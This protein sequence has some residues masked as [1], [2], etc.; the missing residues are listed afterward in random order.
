MHDNKVEQV[1]DSLRSTVYNLETM[2][3]GSDDAYTRS[4]C[5]RLNQQISRLEDVLATNEPEQQ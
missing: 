4:L 2:V 3:Q 1:I 5:D